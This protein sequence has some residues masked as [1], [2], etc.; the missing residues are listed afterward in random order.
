MRQTQRG[1]HCPLPGRGW[2]AGGTALWSIEVSDT[3]TEL[4]ETLC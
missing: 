4:V 2:E 3:L 1:T